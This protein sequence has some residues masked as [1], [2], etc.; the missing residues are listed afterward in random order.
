VTPENTAVLSSGQ[1]SVTLRCRTN[2]TL[3]FSGAIGWTH[4][5]VNGGTKKVVSACIVGPQSVYNITRDDSTGHCDLVIND[6]QPAVT[7]I[8]SCF[9]SP[10]VTASAHVTIIC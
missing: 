10:E 6:V 2:D 9:Q 3:A 4:T 5:L 8:Y 7:G 1:R